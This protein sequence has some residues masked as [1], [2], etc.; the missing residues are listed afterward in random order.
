MN[1]SIHSIVRTRS[2]GDG[3]SELLYKRP[4]GLL[5]KPGAK[6]N[7]VDHG[8]YY[9]ASGASEA[10]TRILIDDIYISSPTIRIAQE[11]TND[12]PKLIGENP[13]TLVFIAGGL[14]IAPCLAYCSNFPS[15]KLAAIIYRHK[16]KGVNNEWLNSYQNTKHIIDMSNAL[17][18]IPIDKKNK[19]YLC[20]DNKQE[21]TL[22]KDYLLNQG[23]KGQ[24]IYTN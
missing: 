18:D 20:N 5:Y 1:Y 13:D 21:N 14:G 12:F 3:V 16:G 15:D 10:W 11:G 22:V 17:K 24:L 4:R 6:V 23:V 19:Y 9:I 7:L 2:F 8:E